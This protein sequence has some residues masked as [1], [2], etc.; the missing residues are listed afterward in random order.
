MRRI[1]WDILFALL[2]GLG[3]GLVYAWMIAPRGA[4]D[5]QPR[6]LRADFK[7]QYR[8]LIAAAYTATG[9]LPRARA[10]LALLGDPDLLEALNGQAQRMQ[11]NNQS[12]ERADQVA[13]LARAL[14]ENVSS[15][16]T[17]GEITG[18]EP[19]S[20]AP[21]PSTTV[22]IA[23]QAEATTPL[24][25]LPPS[26]EVTLDV[27]ETPQTIET[28]TVVSAS[29]PRPTNTAT[30]AP[31]KPFKLT[32]QDTVCDPNL[33]NG[34]LQVLVLNSNR[35]QIAG[36]EIDVTWDG[37]EE[38]FFTGLKPELGNGYA[39]YMMSPD[40]IYSIKLARGSDVASGI[41]AP[42]CQSPNGEAFPGGIKLTF[43]QP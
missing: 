11:A 23:D 18:A 10:R 35:R 43:Q 20:S 5:T 17:N 37:G 42:S 8:A 29:T 32:G 16:G 14:D 36:V 13:A 12:F 28:S 2:V 26:S 9:N 30:P 39:D 1:P 38:Q 7:D 15:A 4:T 22:E 6:T 24:T 33:P 3:A 19:T 34:L 27:T 41:T 31:G 40:I 21:V 25:S